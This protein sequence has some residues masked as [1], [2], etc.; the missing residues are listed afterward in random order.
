MLLY[1]RL[2]HFFTLFGFF[3]AF[4]RPQRAFV[5]NRDFWTAS[6]RTSLRWPS[7]AFSTPSVGCRERCGAPRPS[8]CRRRALSTDR[9]RRSMYPNMFI[10]RHAQVSSG[11]QSHFI[12]RKRQGGSPAIGSAFPYHCHSS[13]LFV[14]DGSLTNKY[15]VRL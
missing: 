2:V 11:P 4:F 13:A 9:C 5:F 8:C 1:V 6:V 15:S 3:S 10:V 7:C 14:A 12:Q